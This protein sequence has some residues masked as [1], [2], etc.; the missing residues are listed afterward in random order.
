MTNEYTPAIG[1]HVLFPHA[2]APWNQTT[3]YT[4]AG[5]GPRGVHITWETGDWTIRMDKARAM[6]IV[7]A[8]TYQQFSSALHR[9]DELV[10]SISEYGGNAA[11]AMIAETFSRLGTSQAMDWRSYDAVSSALNAAA[12]DASEMTDYE[13]SDTI[14]DDSARDLAV[15]AALHLL[16][17]PDASLYDVVIEAHKDT[18]PSFDDLDEGQPEPPKG[19]EAWNNALYETVTG[20]IA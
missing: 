8:Y 12:N 7:R 4:V 19:S 3:P 5:F 11:H 18:E 13:N 9:A 16:D 10:N 14:R 1:D 20:W 6:G 15:N 17:H 2:A